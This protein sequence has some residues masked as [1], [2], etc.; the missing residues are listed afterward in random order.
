MLLQLL[1]MWPADVLG[2]A[3][4]MLTSGGARRGLDVDAARTCSAARHAV[5]LVAH[6]HASAPPLV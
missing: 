5:L 1:Q 2:T 6:K 4:A 3:C